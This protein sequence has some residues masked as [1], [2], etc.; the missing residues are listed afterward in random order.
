MKSLKHLL[1]PFLF[2]LS[3]SVAPAQSVVSVAPVPNA[4]TP[5]TGATNLG[6][7]INNAPGATDTGIAVLFTSR[8]TLA[9]TGVTATNYDLAATTKYRAQ[10]TFDQEKN[11][12]TYR[13]STAAGGI[14]SAV[15]ATDIAI[16][17]GNATNTV[18][19]TKVIISGVQTSAG[20]VLVNII[21][22]SAANTTGT[23]A[24]MTSVPLDSTDSAASS[25]PLSYTAN[26]TPGA[27]VGIVDSVYLSVSPAATGITTSTYVFNFGERGKGIKLS[28]VAQGLAVNLNGVTVTGG[29][30][31]ITYEWREEP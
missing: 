5:G 17:P 24:A 23:S 13:A 11:L 31:V 26:P 3:A 10:Y 25:L 28:G 1:L 20:E 19:V 2:I 30:F 8:P 16:L 29:N 15:T 7:A 9:A 27:T 6:K 4:V 12:P 14:A 22:R 21:K 18:Y